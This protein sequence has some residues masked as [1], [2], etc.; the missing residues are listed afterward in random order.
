MSGRPQGC[1]AQ[2]AHILAGLAAVALVVALPI[3]L[4]ARN[5]ALVLFEPQALAEAISVRLIESGLLR[6]TI[7]DSLLGGDASEEALDLEAALQYLPPDQRRELLGRLVPGTWVHDQI[8][9]VTTDLFAWFDS[10]ST[11]LLLTVDASPVSAGLENE[12]G[13]VVEAIVESW[14]SCTLEDVGKM[15]S[16]GAAPGEQGFPFCEPPEP[17]RG[18]VVSG[19]TVTLRFVAQTLPARVPI[20]DETF[21]DTDELLASKEQVR[22]VHFVARWGILV[23]LGLLGIITMAVIRSWKGL[24][25]WWGIPLLAGGILAFLPAWFGGRIVSLM[26]GRLTGGMGAL[27]ALRELAE[28]L[29]RAIGGAVL[30]AQARH[31][32]LVTLIGL[33]LVVA[34]SIRRRPPAA[35]PAAA[36]VA[37][38]PSKEPSAAPDAAEEPRERPSGMFG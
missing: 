2:A 24:A 31:A 13:A 3:T 18:V 15:I 27:P 5:V 38:P 17:L 4:F 30:E 33:V 36:R 22:M 28:A 20:V 26:T 6:D 10:P 21:A 11:R 29:V 25:R 34:S 16:L 19:L 35:A 8:V 9:Q 12:A 1:A 37:P 23:C 32:A 14:P 7:V